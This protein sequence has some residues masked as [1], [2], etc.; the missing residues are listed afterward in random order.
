MT[1]SPDLAELD[2]AKYLR[3]TTFKRDGTAVPTP[4]WFVVD[5]DTVLVW[6]D[7]SSGKAKRIR[8]N[9]GVEVALCDSRGKPKG[10]ARPAQAALL[11]DLADHRRA[12]DLL[13]RKY[14]LM[15][16]GIELGQVVNRLVRRRPEG[17]EAV[18]A[19]TLQA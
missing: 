19:I 14:G 11:D 3:L 17:A 4:V 9:A 10:V 2:R 1:A 8:N 18:V 6:T 13:D 16:R 5:G 12:H 15:K 7:A